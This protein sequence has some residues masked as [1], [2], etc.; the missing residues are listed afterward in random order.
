MRKL[1]RA[2]TQASN[3]RH[4]RVGQLSRRRF[5]AIRVDKGAYFLELCRYVVL[6]P[7]RAGIVDRPEAWLWSSD[8][9]AMGLDPVPSCLHA[10]GLLENLDT[11]RRN[12][13]M[14][15][16]R[17]VRAGVG[18]RIW[19]GPRRQIDRGDDALAEKMQRR[20]S[21]RS[22]TASAGDCPGNPACAPG[23]FA[24]DR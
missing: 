13:R 16:R 9:P 7:V 4:G 5:E 15:D 12:A 8:R 14:H 1:N 18:E 21:V 23:V 17:F 11:D 24:G 22:S 19:D 2:C 20:A 10:D 3:R 6:N